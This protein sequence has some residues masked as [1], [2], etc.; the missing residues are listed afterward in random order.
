MKAYYFNNLVEI[1]K[2]KGVPFAV[3]S[4]YSES[5]K[6]TKSISGIKFTKT[7]KFYRANGKIIPASIY[8]DLQTIALTTRYDT[9]RNKASDRPNQ[10]RSRSKAGLS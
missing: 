10:L 6:E 5:G 2:E 8:R 9:D 7:G 3:K 4:V 1:L